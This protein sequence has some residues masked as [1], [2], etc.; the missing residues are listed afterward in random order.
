MTDSADSGETYSGKQTLSFLLRRFAQAGIRPRTNLGQHFLVDPNLQRLLV[1]A[2]ELGPR[3]VVLEVGTGTG[4]MTV[5]LAPAAA[6]VVT[7]EIDARLFQLAGESLGALPNVRMLRLDALRRKSQ[8][9][10][11]L[12]AAVYSELD[13][14]PGRQFK[15]VANLPYLIA[16]PL[17]SNLLALPRPPQSMTVTIQKE[18]ADR[19][20]AAPGTKDYGALSV[21]IQSQC[22][23]EIVRHLPPSVFWPR[24]KV[25]SSIVRLVLD[26]RL[27]ARIADLDSFHSLLRA[28]FAHRRKF[29]RSE[30]AIALRDRLG[31]SKIDQLLAGLGVAPQV[32]AEQLDVDTLLALCQAIGNRGQGLG[33]RD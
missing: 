1:E 30:L 15:L 21:W 7:A 14:A 27:R 13:A 20:T 4:S 9:D 31:K 19:I 8:V 12:L 11:E 28:L 26:G 16:T 18:L 2:A 3:D 29:L 10:P 25:S 24:P 33:D 17:L 22:R 23:V 5:L 6:A 32:R